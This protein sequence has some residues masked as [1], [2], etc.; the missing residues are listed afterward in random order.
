MR[1]S[2][3]RSVSSLV[4]IALAIVVCLVG[5]ALPA[6]AQDATGG[7]PSQAPAA[8]APPAAQY[9]ATGAP[10]GYPPPGY[11]P[12]GYPQAGYP[13]PGYPQPGYPQGGFPQPIYSS[14]DVP[15][16][17]VEEEPA[18]PEFRPFRFRIDFGFGGFSPTEV[19]DYLASKMPSN[20]Y[21]ESGTTDMIMI[22]Q[23]E[24]AVA[25]YF[26]PYLGI[27]PTVTYLFSP[28]A[29]VVQGGSSEG[30]WLHSIAPGLSIDGALPVGRVARLFLSP[31]LAY[32][33]GWLDSYSASGL[34][35][36]VSGG[37]DLSFGTAR[38]KGMYIA[39]TFRKANLGVSSDTRYSNTSG[40]GNLTHLDFTSFIISIGFQLSV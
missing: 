19:N 21:M 24:A 9:P 1:T 39:G 40:S 29:F 8:G 10:A 22:F 4:P 25:Y 32:Q 15:T 36:T 23:L 33:A 30:F 28:K 26:I 27:R 12:P 11:P 35:I 31:G 34:G 20:A 18:T 3:H 2:F 17:P 37:V 38:S 14:P 7:G 16:E 6:Y 5:A 13:P